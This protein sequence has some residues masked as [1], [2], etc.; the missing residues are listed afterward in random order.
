[1][2]IISKIQQECNRVR[3]ELLP[4]YAAIPEGAIA[5]AMMRCSIQ[6]AEQAVASGDPAA[7]V[8]ALLD[9][10]GYTL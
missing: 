8:E 9:L 3:D 4:V 6:K 1:M 5:A 10:R 2:N 7:C